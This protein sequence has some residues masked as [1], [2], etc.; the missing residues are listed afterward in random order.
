MLCQDI[1]DDVSSSD[2]NSSTSSSS[3]WMYREDIHWVSDVM[4]KISGISNDELINKINFNSEHDYLLTKNYSLTK[5]HVDKLLVS[6]W[7]Y[8]EEH[9]LSHPSINLT[10]DQKQPKV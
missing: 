10:K 2:D 6:Q 9:E 1:T 8:D 5:P 4:D 3:E 7:I